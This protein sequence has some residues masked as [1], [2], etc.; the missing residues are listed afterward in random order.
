MYI[1]LGHR[2]RRDF[3]ADTCHQLGLGGMMPNLPDHFQVQREPIA[4]YSH[5]CERFEVFFHETIT[6]GSYHQ[7]WSISSNMTSQV[8]SQWDDRMTILVSKHVRWVSL[9]DWGICSLVWYTLI[10]QMICV[11]RS[12]TAFWRS[13]SLFSTQDSFQGIVT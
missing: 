8:Y 1:Y 4:S 9:R 11:Q 12:P 10:C 5:H 13:K 7:V 3:L 2:H 6:L